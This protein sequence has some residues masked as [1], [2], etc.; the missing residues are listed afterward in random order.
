M[1]I[2]FSREGKGVP[3]TMEIVDGL[4]WINPSKLTIL[5][6]ILRWNV[7]PYLKMENKYIF[8]SRFLEEYQVYPTTTH[9]KAAIILFGKLIKPEGNFL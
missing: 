5:E 2:G 4:I 8:I 6:A 3:D 7:F 1:Q 9:S